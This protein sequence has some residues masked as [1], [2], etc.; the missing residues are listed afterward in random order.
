MLKFII[1]ILMI[2]FIAVFSSNLIISQE[3]NIHNI[4]LTKIDK[5]NIRNLELKKMISKE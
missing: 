3:A 5:K 1:K 2:A 4:D